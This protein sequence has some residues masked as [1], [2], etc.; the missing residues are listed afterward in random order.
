MS[1]LKRPRAVQ[2]IRYGTAVHGSNGYPSKSAARTRVNKD[3][4]ARQEFAQLHPELQEQDEHKIL[5]D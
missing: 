2:E 3:E 1:R 4:L 5:R